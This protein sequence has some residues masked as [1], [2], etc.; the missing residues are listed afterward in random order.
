MIIVQQQVEPN[1]LISQT[2]RTKLKMHIMDKDTKERDI[3]ATDQ[4]KVVGVDPVKMVFIETLQKS[5]ILTGIQL[6]E[7]EGPPDV[8]YVSPIF[9]GQL[10]AQI[11]L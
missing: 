11:S 7:M 9:I 6:A 8:I 10:I 4:F 1:L 5:L 2:L 3:I